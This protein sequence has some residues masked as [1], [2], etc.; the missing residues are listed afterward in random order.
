MT[1]YTVQSVFLEFSGG[2]GKASIA[3][4]AT[5]VDTGTGYSLNRTVVNPSPQAQSRLNAIGA[6]AIAYIQSKYPTITVTLG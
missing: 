1:T 2:V 5:D 3:V 4:S 6:D